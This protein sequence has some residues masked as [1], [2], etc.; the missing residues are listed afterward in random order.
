MRGS[1]FCANFFGAV[2]DSCVM[3]KKIC[4]LEVKNNSCQNGFKYFILFLNEFEYHQNIYCEPTRI[5]LLERKDF[6]LLKK[7]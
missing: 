2:D 4:N 5:V 3:K 1:S 6:I 7:G